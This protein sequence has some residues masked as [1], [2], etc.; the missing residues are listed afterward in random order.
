MKFVVL[1]L[2]PTA[3]LVGGITLATRYEEKR[4]VR[5]EAETSITMETETTVER[6][7]EPVEMPGGGGQSSAT[8]IKEVH[9]DTIVSAE[10]GAPTKVRRVFESLG[11]KRSSTRGERSN[12]SEIESPIEGLTVDFTAADGEVSFEVVEG[13]KPDDE[14]AFE[15]QHLQSF[16][17]FALPSGEVE[18]GDSWELDKD[19]VL[20]L[21]RVD[22]HRGLFPPA[23]RPEG[24]GEGGGRGRRGGGRMGGGGDVGSLAVADWK[25]KATLKK[26]AEDV[27][28]TKCAVIELELTAAGEM[29]MPAGGMGRGP[30]GGMAGPETVAVFGATY[31]FKLEGK[32]CF[33]VEARRPVSLEIEGKLSNTIDQE[34]EGR[35]GGSMKIH[36]QRD[37]TFKLEVTV[38]EEKA[39]DK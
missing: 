16:L 39:S 18:E 11:G 27:D 5:V 7:G 3:L 36:A 32:L 35:D 24:E 21:L 33:A 25:G 37:G 30:R 34:M 9:V 4:V 8:E 14:K 22:A 20:A 26:A 23:A 31:D 13:T 17:D 15:K 28:G 38:S 1:A 2:V 6:D 19:Q 10:K 29:E 12:E